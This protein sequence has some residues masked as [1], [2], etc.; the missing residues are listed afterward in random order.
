MRKKRVVQEGKEPQVQRGEGLKKPIEKAGGKRG[1][2]KA[3]RT[4]ETDNAKEGY[5]E[6]K[7]YGNRSMFEVVEQRW[8]N[9]GG[10]RPRKRERN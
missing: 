8:D 3:H 6:K 4:G 7:R 2:G 5:E 10:Q 1:G 9:R